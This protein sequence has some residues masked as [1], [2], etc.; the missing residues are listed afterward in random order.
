MRNVTDSEKCQLTVKNVT[1]SEKC[2]LTVKIVT[3]EH[4]SLSKIDSENGTPREL[5]AVR[6]P[7]VL[8]SNFHKMNCFAYELMDF[9]ISMFKLAYGRL[10][11]RLLVCLWISCTA[12]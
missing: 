6:K 9:F 4:F 3:C 1:D 10:Y 8:M 12:Y 7:Y 5:I 2:Q 11:G